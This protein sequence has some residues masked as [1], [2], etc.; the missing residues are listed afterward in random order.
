MKQFN[1]SQL[2]EEDKHQIEMF[3]SLFGEPNRPLPKFLTWEQILEV[4][5]E[6]LPNERDI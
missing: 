2:T 5:K 6:K 4:L 1:P 3:L